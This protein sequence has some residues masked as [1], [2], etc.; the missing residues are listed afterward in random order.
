MRRPLLFS[1]G[2]VLAVSQFA[3][4]D[5]GAGLAEG[6]G[7]REMH[8]GDFNGAIAEYSKAIELAL[9]LPFLKVSES[10]GNHDSKVVG[11]GSVD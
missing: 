9:Q 1:V 11:A 3:C 10:M 6:H 4:S 7:H 2:F 8:I 5:I